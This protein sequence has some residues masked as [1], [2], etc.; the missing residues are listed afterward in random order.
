MDCD[1]DKLLK[2]VW[3]HYWIKMSNSKK[4]KPK[5]WQQLLKDIEK[6]DDEAI[7]SSRSLELE[8]FKKTTLYKW[9]QEEKSKTPINRS[10][11]KMPRICEFIKKSGLTKWE[12]V[13][14][15]MSINGEKVAKSFPNGQ[16]VADGI[17]LYTL[18]VIIEKTAYGMHI[19]SYTA[20]DK[21]CVFNH[22]SEHKSNGEFIR[23]VMNMFDFVEQFD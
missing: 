1:F 3:C 5:T 10:G 20:P 11:Y 13:E 19:T 2:N 22:K 16:Q 12:I 18:G 6:A 15:Y 9:L 21:V 4:T 14:S 8:T 7:K 17:Y 23:G